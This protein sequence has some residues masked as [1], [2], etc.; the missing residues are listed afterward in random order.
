MADSATNDEI[1]AFRLSAHHLDERLDH[2]RLGEAAGACGIQNS[3][4]GSALTAL[5]A[6]VENM[7][8]AGFASAIA[9]DKSLVQTWCMRG[10]PFVVPTSDLAVFTTGVLPQTERALR[11]FVL[12]VE[13]SVDDLG[14]ELSDLV[15]RSE[16]EV[17]EVL[18]GRR[19][20]I[21]ELGAEVADR[22]GPSLTTPQRKV[23]ES[24]GPYAKGQSLGAG[25]VHFCIRLLTL[26]QV[27]CFAPREGNTAPFVLLDEWIDEPSI[28]SS[29]APD[30]NERDRARAELL[31]RYLHC[32]GPSTRADFAAWL[33][34]RSTE[35]QPWWDLLDGQIT[36]IDCGRRAWMLAEDVDRL[37][38]AE[39]PRGVRL[40]PPHDPY[41]QM[42]DRETI[43]PKEHHREVWKTVGDPGTL[44]VDGR[45]VGTWRVRKQNR[46]LN[47]RFAPFGTVSTTLKRALRSEAEAIAALREASGAEIEFCSD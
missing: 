7:S 26:R 31:R 13:K 21:T 10:A 43:V 25:V 11:H 42:R 17:R 1:I 45:I 40:L 27:L 14:L 2:N 15:D 20:T 23:W 41:T 33:G 5:H 39:L 6:R 34:I 44:L 8:E 22:L 9:E 19:L 47:I 16:S 28:T 18:P 36:E 35:A 29:Q 46:R 37:H 4:P 24:D 32:Y 30:G 3:P 12:G 38:R